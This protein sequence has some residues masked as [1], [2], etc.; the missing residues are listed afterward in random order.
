MG[1]FYQILKSSQYPKH[2]TIQI[3]RIDC[4]SFRSIREK[5]N[6]IYLNF[7]FL[8]GGCTALHPV[9]NFTIKK[10]EMWYNFY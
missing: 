8:K 10:K 6:R 1:I 9:A 3:K 4:C 2:E 7:N 5:K